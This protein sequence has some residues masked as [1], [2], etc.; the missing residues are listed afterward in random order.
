[1]NCF[2]DPLPVIVVAGIIY[3]RQTQM[4]QKIFM[5]ILYRGAFEEIFWGYLKNQQITEDFWTFKTISPPQ[6]MTL[7]HKSNLVD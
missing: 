5:Y 6:N 1:M 7:A 3:M 2:H 4:H